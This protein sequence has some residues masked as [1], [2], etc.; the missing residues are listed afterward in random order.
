MTLAHDDERQLAHI[1]ARFARTH[2]P[3]AHLTAA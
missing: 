1:N 3:G 2:P